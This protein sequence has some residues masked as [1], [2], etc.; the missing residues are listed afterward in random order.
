MK[1][2]KQSIQDSPDSKAGSLRLTCHHKNLAS[3]LTSRFLIQDSETHSSVTLSA[4]LVAGS[5]SEELLHPPGNIYRH[6]CLRCSY[7]NLKS[8]NAPEMHPQ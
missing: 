8:K 4:E 6:K 2:M 1:T 7:H 5:G 3:L